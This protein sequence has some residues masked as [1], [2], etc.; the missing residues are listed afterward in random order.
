[1]KYINLT[2]IYKYWLSHNYK[3]R[4][5]QFGKPDTPIFPE[6]Q[7]WSSTYGLAPSC[8]S[9][10]FHASNTRELQ[11]LRVFP[12]PLLS[13]ETT[14][15]G[16]SKIPNRSIQFFQACQICHQQIHNTNNL[17]MINFLLNDLYFKCNNKNDLSFIM[18]FLL[19]FMC[20]IY[21]HLLN[22][23]MIHLLF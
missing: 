1:M 3:N 23:R 13:S 19:S 11:S 14:K 12:L 21:L 4:M 15:T 20:I 5:F 17:C 16:S 18:Y 2:S 7:I 9:F 8:F 22:Y 6:C 10:P